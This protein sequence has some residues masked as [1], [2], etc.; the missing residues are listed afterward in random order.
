MT[1]NSRYGLS[2]EEEDKSDKYYVVLNQ[3]KVE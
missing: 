2:R 3:M 1:N